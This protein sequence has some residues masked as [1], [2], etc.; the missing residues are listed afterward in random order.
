MRGEKMAAIVLRQAERYTPALQRQRQDL[1][2]DTATQE[3]GDFNGPLLICLRPST[4][5]A[6]GDAQSF[7]MGEGQRP[8]SRTLV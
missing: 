4:T 2:V 6:D 1:C 7:R 3:T 5:M 8:S